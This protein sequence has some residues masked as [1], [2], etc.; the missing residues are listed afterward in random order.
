MRGLGELESAVMSRLWSWGRPAA[1]REVLEDL[2]RERM[3][4]YTTVAT[5]L[6]NLCRKGLAHRERSGRVY[7]YEAVGTR[8]DYNARLMNEVLAGDADRAA[9]LLRFVEQM[10]PDEVALLRRAFDA[11]AQE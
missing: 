5:V 11:A 9:T 6:D 10:T 4:A 1:A 2:Q 3:F 8:E 7:R